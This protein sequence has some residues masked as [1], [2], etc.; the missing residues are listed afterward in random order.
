M[1][2][3]QK[4]KVLVQ[5]GTNDGNDEFR[6]VVLRSNPTKVILVE[7]NSSLN[8]KIHLNYN[9]VREMYLENVVITDIDK[10]I[11]NLVKPKNIITSTGR[12][13][14]GLNYTSKHY[15]LLPM[16]DWGDDFDV[17]EVESMS[18]MTLCEKHGLTDIHYLQIDT[19]GYDAEIIRAIDFSRVN[20]DIIKYEKWFFK[21]E[22]FMRYGDKKKR[23]G[24]NGMIAV[25]SLLKSLNYA[26]I[27]D[28]S[29][30]IAIKYG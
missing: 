30:I 18:F 23:Y 26:M 15:S 9:G 3:I 4:N 19:E 24:V 22:C 2:R 25:E 29:D 27:H 12:Y 1:V 16:D 11:Q 13:Y 14:K 17:I 8:D 6:D 28:R 20:I 7:P 5:I 10:G 21:E